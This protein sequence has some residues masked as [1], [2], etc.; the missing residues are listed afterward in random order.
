L[1]LP[2]PVYICSGTEVHG[3][4]IIIIIIIIMRRRR[5]RRKKKKR[6]SERE[7]EHRI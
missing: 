5:R 2:S 7:I 4:I 1:L 6:R 3:A